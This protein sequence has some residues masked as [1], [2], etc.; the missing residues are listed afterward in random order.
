[1]NTPATIHA[2][3]LV[4][5]GRGVLI[6]GASGAGKSSLLLAILYAER[7]RARLVADD[8]V[9]VTNVDQRLVARAPAELAGKLEVRGQGIFDQPY[10]A[11]AAIDL[12]VDML[13]LAES[14]RFPEPGHRCTVINGISIARIEIATGAADGPARVAFALAGSVD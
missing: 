8:R 5:G 12:V 10:A 9:V 2:S 11:S 14:T 7:P 4:V 6:R 13:P 3:A 1:M